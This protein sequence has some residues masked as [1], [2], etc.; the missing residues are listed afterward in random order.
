MTRMVV[1]ACIGCGAMGRPSGCPAGCREERLD[2]VPAVAGDRV[3]AIIAG[4]P[5][6]QDALR[7][8]LRELIG[9]PGA[10]SPEA[11]FALAQTSARS[12]LGARGCLPRLFQPEDPVTTWW[13][14]DCGGLEAPQPCL[15]VCVWR[16]AEWVPAEE[17]GRARERANT[18]IDREQ[19]L[20]GPLARL[21]TITPRPGRWGESL[22]ALQAAARAALAREAHR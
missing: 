15:G 10:E 9:A 4:A 19:A 13:C 5:D 17:F 7:V 20:R 21:S 3:K 18:L 22:E 11:A 1:P 8:A 16:R 14:P 6:R 2:L 12:A